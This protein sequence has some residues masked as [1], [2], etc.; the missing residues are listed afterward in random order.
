MK[1]LKDIENHLPISLCSDLP[2]IELTGNREV[3]MEGCTGVLKYS[4]DNIKVNTNSMV[5]SIQGRGLNLKC[6]SSSSLV[7]SGTVLSVEFIM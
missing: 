2:I 5:V 4:S 1:R 7:I 3:N 6:I